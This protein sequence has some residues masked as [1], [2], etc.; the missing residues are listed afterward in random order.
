MHCHTASSV[1]SHGVT[2][3]GCPWCVAACASGASTHNR[4]R[5]R[6]CNG[7]SGHAAR[8]GGGSE[9]PRMRR[10]VGGRRLT[11]PT[12]RCPACMRAL[13]PM[14]AQG[15]RNTFCSTS[16]SVSNLMSGG[17]SDNDETTATL[18]TH[19]PLG[20][21]R[22]LRADAHGQQTSRAQPDSSNDSLTRRRAHLRHSTW[23]QLLHV[24]L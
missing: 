10:R 2:R 21:Q 9:V 1:C 7:A 3:R 4:P 12:T 19:Q 11:S 6:P 22:T 13:E 18:W 8:G 23:E 20:S 17:M 14:P 15:T 24:N 16:R 5:T